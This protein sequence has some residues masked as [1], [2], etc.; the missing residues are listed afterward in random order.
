M[1]D[2]QKNFASQL[3]KNVRKMTPSVYVVVNETVFDSSMMPF[4][5][6]ASKRS[7]SSVWTEEGPGRGLESS[8]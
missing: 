1:P 3:I 7:F 2:I 6:Y 8:R 5:G 4:R